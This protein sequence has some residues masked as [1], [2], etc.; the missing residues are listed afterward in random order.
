VVALARKKAAGG[1]RAEARKRYRKL[2]PDVLIGG[3]RYEVVEDN[4]MSEYG[5]CEF[6]LNRIKIRVL[7]SGKGKN[8]ARLAPGIIL[9]TLVHE[10]MHASIDAHNIGGEARSRF[11]LSKKTW[12]TLEEDVF[13]R[14]GVPAV[15]PCLLAIFASTFGK[16]LA[17][18]L[19]TPAA[20]RRTNRRKR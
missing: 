16:S 20:S 13:L 19:S 9:D 7:V 4:E 12:T 8:R 15:L 11:K 5:L 10:F 1:T 3:Q 14:L 6:E 18:R 2:M 17:S